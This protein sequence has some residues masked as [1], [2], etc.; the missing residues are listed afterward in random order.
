VPTIISRQQAQAAGLPRFFT[1]KACIHGHLAE[2]YTA[3]RVCTECHKRASI[4]YNARNADRAR[5]TTAAWQKANPDRLRAANERHSKTQ[6]RRDSLR[7]FQRRHPQRI[8][9]KNRLRYARKLSQICECCTPDTIRAVY[10]RC[11]RGHEVDHRIPLAIGGLHCVKNLQILS[12]AEH[13]AK[14]NRDFLLIWQ[15]RKAA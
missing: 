13:R 7:N 10:E 11:P 4:D 2:R 14:T 5:E 6:K 15:A 9:A 12:R 3:G 8:N 1:G